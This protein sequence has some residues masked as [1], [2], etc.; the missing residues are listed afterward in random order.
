MTEEEGMSMFNP[1][2]MAISA[3]NSGYRDSAMAL[4]ELIDNSL[5]AGAAMVDVLVGEK[6]AKRDGAAMRTRHMHQIAVLDNGKGMDAALLQRALRFGD[7]D[8]HMDAEGMG[9]FGV[10]LPQA[11]ISQAKRVDVWS[12]Q[13]GY[14]SAHHA[15]IDLSDR[16]W[17]KRGRIL[18][19]DNEPIDEYWVQNSD[20]FSSK[21]GTLV[22]WSQLDKTTW[23][24]AE[25]LFDNS[26]FLIGRMYR[27]WLTKDNDEKKRKAQI[28]LTS[29]PLHDSDELDTHMY[30]YNPNDP[31][32]RLKGSDGMNSS[33]GRTILFNEW[34]AEIT[35]PYQV[36][37]SAQEVTFRFTLA[38]KTSGL[39]EPH[40][41]TD[42]GVLDYGKHAKK[43]IGVSIM[44][45]GRELELE[46]KFITNTP[47]DPRQR[48]WGAEV[49]FP[50]AMDDIFGV[51]NNKQAAERLSHFANKSWDDVTEKKETPIQAKARI[52]KEDYS[53]YV[54]LDVATTINDNISKMFTTIKKTTTSSKSGRARHQDSPEV[55]GTKATEKRKED[56]A[57]EGDSDPDEELST[58][59]RKKL[60]EEFLDRIE[61]DHAEE[62]IGDILDSGLKY[63]FAHAHMSDDA[64]F[65]VDGVAGAIVIT[66]NWDHA[67]YSALFETLGQDTSDLTPQ[68]LNQSLLKANSAV[69]IMLI[70]WARFEDEASGAQKIRLKDSRND[71]GR[72]TRDFLLFGRE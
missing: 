6:F 1:E 21:T 70:A 2:M 66:L 32:Y 53:T 47:K 37:G 46:T 17:L 29:F 11:S 18:N 40:D 20:L 69:L 52:K 71:W 64:F 63:T 8:H 72:I 44:R 22:V 48:W 34:G 60:L 68:Q 13:D 3:R 57:I 19:P 12:W 41:G 31:L 15:F 55:R 7:G 30:H 25:T 27:N 59:E 24:K 49:D 42:A 33:S 54:C 39:R 62:N 43:N 38:D 26:N 67:A 45:A 4:G 16:T 10:G 61:P 36:D 50:P 23:T 9:K 28:R 58:E 56:T 65:T 35:K 14:E 5:Q 51:A